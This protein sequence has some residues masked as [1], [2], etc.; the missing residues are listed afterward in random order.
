ML[1][2]ALSPIDIVPDFIPVL[3]LLDDLIV[4]PLGLW[5]TLQMIPDDVMQDARRAAS[6]M[7]A[8]NEVRLPANYYAAAVIVALWLIFIALLVHVACKMGTNSKC[9]A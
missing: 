1:A 3:G 5:L 6:E 2:L 4:I 9:F 7:D 8:N